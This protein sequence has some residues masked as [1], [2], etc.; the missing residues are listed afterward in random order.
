LIQGWG[1]QGH[2]TSLGH[3]PHNYVNIYVQV[4]DLERFVERAVELGGGVVIPPMEI[5][6]GRGH[7]A[8]IRDVEGTVVGLFKPPA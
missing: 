7:F 6:G 8:W 2:V 4:D 3:E 1:V 5:P